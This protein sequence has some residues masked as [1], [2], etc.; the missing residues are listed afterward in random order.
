MATRPYHVRVVDAAG[1]AFKLP[2]EQFKR[3][4]RLQ[5]DAALLDDA[6]ISGGGGSGTVTNTG[7]L[8]D[9]ALMVG[10]SGVDVQ[11]LGSL[12]TT[13]TVLHGN[14]A[15]DP[16]FAA[17]ALGAD[18]SGDLPFANLAQGAALSVLG[19]AGNATADHASIASASDKQVLRRSGTALAFGAVDLTSSAAVT[20]ILP[21]ANIA[22]GTPT[23]AKFVRDDGVLAVPAGT[24]TVTNTG[25]LTANK[26]I[27]GNGTVDVTVSAASGVAHLASGVLT[28]SNVDLTSEVT[29]DLPFANLVQA[30]G[31]SKVVGRGSASGGGDF[32]ELTLGANLSLSGTVLNAIGGGGSGITTKLYDVTLGADT[33]AFDTD[34]TDLSGYDVLEGWMIARCDEAVVTSQGKITINNDGG[35]NY[36]WQTCLTLNVTVQAGVG[37]GVAFAAFV[38]PG[39]SDTAGVAGL[40]RFSIPGY[41]GTTFHKT[42]EYRTGIP[43]QTA[44]NR[45]ID[46][47]NSRWRSTAAITRL[48]FTAP[49]T[50]KWVTGSRL[51]IYGR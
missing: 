6:D 31:A 47:W 37:T 46:M 3:D 28:G 49:A 10:N 16:T 14:A 8:T 33:A 51:V 34:P 9:H 23:G 7:G 35:N 45:R 17:V 26:A 44:A 18:V 40:M 29:G 50:K 12:G 38:M 22:T 13:V 42:L 30:S 32:Q 5:T 2:Y 41:L 43:D 19:V 24:G 25:T 11:A 15:G 36:D 39:A 48:A 1:D 27:I 4:K 20:G 21:I